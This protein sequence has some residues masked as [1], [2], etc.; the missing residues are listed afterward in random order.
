MNSL[1][2]TISPLQASTGKQDSKQSDILGIGALSE[3]ELSPV[4]RKPTNL[5]VPKKA[6]AD[7]GS[8]SAMK[9]EE[10]GDSS[11]NSLLAFSA[12]DDDSPSEGPFT[13]VHS[14]PL[15]H[16]NSNRRP[17]RS[18]SPAVASQVSSRAANASR[19]PSPSPSSKRSPLN[20]Q[21]NISFPV[22]S[23]QETQKDTLK[24][25]L[26]LSKARENDLM[27]LLEV[28]IILSYHFA[29]IISIT[30]S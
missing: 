30:V 22:R 9:V 28:A 16:S 17:L 8:T 4:R 2:L 26:R 20:G 6:T 29:V 23:P 3:K 14:P 1:D 27:K 12:L 19:S 18:L 25:E 15:P 11:L 10:G 13:P 24:E 7:T 21:G 5:P